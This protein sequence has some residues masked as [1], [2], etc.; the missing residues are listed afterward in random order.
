MTKDSGP[1]FLPHQERVNLE[2]FKAIEILGRKLERSETG[3]DESVEALARR[4]EETESERS[5]LSRRL[6]LIE[7]SATV[8]AKTGKLSL[9]VVLDPDSLS[10]LAASPAPKWPVMAILANSAIALFTLGVVMF[11]QPPAPGQVLTPRQL[12]ALN[13]LSTRDFAQFEDRAWRKAAETEEV[14]G[15]SAT[16]PPLPPLVTPETSG[17]QKPE[18]A[19]ATPRI[20]EAKPEVAEATPA[21][22]A[23]TVAPAPVI[24]PVA[25][26]TP[27]KTEPKKTETAEKTEKPEKP[28]HVASAPP[29]PAKEAMAE[30]APAPKPEPVKEAA[31]TP[32]KDVPVAT[33]QVDGT[34]I[35]PDANLPAKLADLEKRAFQNVPEAQHDLATLYASGKVVAQDY[36]RAAYWFSKAADG[37]VAN[38]DYNLGVMFQQGL[39]VKQ[40]L[41][42]AIGWYRRAADIGHPEAMYNLGI[43]YIEGVGAPKDIEKGVAYFKSAANAGVAQAAYNLGVLYESSFVGAADTRK[44]QEWYQVAANE[45][46]ADA[47]S[48][49]TRLKTQ[50]AK[51]SDDK[52]SLTV[53]DLVEPA[54]GEVGE[55]DSSPV[56]SSHLPPPTFKGNLVSQ[57]QSALARQGLLPKGAVTGTLDSQTGDAIR[58]WQKKAGQPVDGTPSQAMLDKMNAVS[59]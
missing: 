40:D 59:K 8:D 50:V 22:P 3:R 12:A 7:S 47:A 5:R 38:A 37:G 34:A 2:I 21:K 28:V 35:T 56:D 53:A 51:A 24:P 20:E 42:K 25:V 39:G 10:R 48:A 31:V 44:A 52:Q 9:P 49:V 17:P 32:P 30:P 41:S 4:L 1:S 15:A 26:K 23:E 13:A 27:E 19:Q 18:T 36:R 29:K 46:H 54:A 57:I 14:A 33:A 55:G 45:G 11:Q 6:A 16:P 43:A 58:A